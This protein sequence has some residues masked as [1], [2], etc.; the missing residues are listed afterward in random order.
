MDGVTLPGCA[1]HH[2][3]AHAANTYYL[4][5]FDRS[6]IFTLDGFGPAPGYHG[7]MFYAGIEEGIYPLWPHHLATGY[8]Y[9]FVANSLGLG[10]GGGPGKLMG[11]AA[12]GRASFLRPEFIGNYYDFQKIFRDAPKNWLYHCVNSAESMGYDVGIYA[13]ADFATAPINA[14]IAASTQRMMELTKMEA[15]RALKMQLVNTGMDTENLCLSGGTALN[16]PSNSSI[17]ASE[18]FEKVYIDPCC[19]DGGISIG[20]ALAVY[21]SILGHRDRSTELGQSPYLGRPYSKSD[22]EQALRNVSNRVVVV[23]AQRPSEEAA[24]DIANNR[25]VGWFEGRSECGPRALGHRSILI[26]P[27]RVDNWKRLNTIKGREAWRPFAPSV[28]AEHA[29]EWFSGVPAS[30]PLMLFNGHVI[31]RKVPAITHVDGTARVQTVDS[32][33]GEFHEVIS[34]FHKISGVPMLLNT[35]MNGPGEPIA[36]SPEDA[37]GVFLNCGLDVLYAG[38]YRISHRS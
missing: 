22:V 14:D 36:E 27:R 29:K 7:G 23:E 5:G 6:A 26:D 13:D 8:I 17:F 33:C 10:V 11:L 28:L 30:S 35:S 9:E 4:S 20:A 1:I 18:L 21:F 2:H 15:V 31:S 34:A 12:Y 25:I 19:D 38:G 16:C 24:H 3:L 32:E 37:L